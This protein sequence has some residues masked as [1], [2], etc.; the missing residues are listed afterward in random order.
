MA[1]EIT[2]CIYCGE[3]KNITR[4]HVPPQCLF[5]DPKPTNMITVPAC[6]PCNESYKLDDEFFR[7]CV[8]SQADLHP[9]GRKLWNEKVTGPTLNRKSSLERSPALANFLANQLITVNLKS[10]T[11]ICLGKRDAILFPA[12]RINRVI[13]RIV[14]GLFWHHYRI[15]I[16]S[17]IGFLSVMNP[18]IEK[19][20]NIINKIAISSIGGDVFY[21][22]Y[23]NV[24]EDPEQSMWFLLFYKRI[25]FS[26]F[27]TRE[28]VSVEEL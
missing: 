21:Y 12:D 8:L 19:I 9:T 24:A 18:N 14:R 3:T 15:R 1:S 20:S 2:R 16:G 13:E 26:A 11:G 28:E 22:R 27:L 7:V 10:E 23:A 25:L 6:K 5:P 4:D 17:N